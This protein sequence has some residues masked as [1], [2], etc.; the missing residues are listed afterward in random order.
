MIIQFFLTLLLGAVGILIGI[1][2]TTTR[3]VRLVILAVIVAGTIFVWVPD[4]T[5]AIAAM[6]GVARGADLLLYLWVILTLALILV[7]YL[8]VIQ[9]GRKITLL[10]RA[11]AVAH[12]RLPD[13]AGEDAQ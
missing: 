12:P 2:R 4:E 11:L 1:Q 8:K 13:V 6:L 10:T 3:L 5:T 7:L 9:M